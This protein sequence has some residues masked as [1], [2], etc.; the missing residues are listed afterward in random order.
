MRVG[1]SNWWIW[2]FHHGD[3]CSF[4]IRP[5]RGK[6]VV[7]E[8]LGDVRPDFWVSDRFGA[9]MG[10]A[11]NEHQVC[12]AHLIRDAQYAIDAGDAIFAPGLRKLLKRACA[13]GRRRPTLADA[14]LR[15]YR[16]AR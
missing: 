12:L 16:R 2:V 8:F 11:R 6:A 14:T 7:E 10:W 3:E 13:I 15:S 1:K 4:V 9:Q 5:S